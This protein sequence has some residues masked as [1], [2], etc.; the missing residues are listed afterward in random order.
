M[1]YDSYLL[2]PE[3]LEKG[4][5]D[6]ASDMWALGCYAYLMYAIMLSQF[7]FSRRRFCFCFCF[8]CWLLLL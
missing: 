2:A 4:S 1:D 8:C 7:M 5:G 3:V 6:A